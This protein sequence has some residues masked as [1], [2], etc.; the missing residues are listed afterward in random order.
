MRHGYILVLRNELSNV[1]HVACNN[2]H[3]GDAYCINQVRNGKEALLLLGFDGDSHSTN[4]WMWVSLA[5]LFFLCRIISVVS[6]SR[7]GRAKT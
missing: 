4:V 3:K 7:A 5:V 6:L 1:H 2:Y